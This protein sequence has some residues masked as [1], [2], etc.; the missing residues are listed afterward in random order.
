[1]PRRPKAE[2]PPLPEDLP[3]R[4]ERIAANLAM[5]IWVPKRDLDPADPVANDASHDAPAKE[6]SREDI[7]QFLAKPVSCATNIVDILGAG[8]GGTR[9]GRAPD[10]K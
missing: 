10:G 5:G 6:A 8:P 7:E 4:E 2:K 9:T 3:T 1:M